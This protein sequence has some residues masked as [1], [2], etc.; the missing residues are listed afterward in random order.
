MTFAITSSDKPVMAVVHYFQITETSLRWLDA[1]SGIDS[2]PAIGPLLR[3][4][5]ATKP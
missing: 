2:L 4:T 3:L 1:I 5:A